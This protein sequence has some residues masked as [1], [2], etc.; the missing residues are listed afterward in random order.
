MAGIATYLAT[1]TADGAVGSLIR[2]TTAPLAIATTIVTIA[3]QGLALAVGEIE[4]TE[5]VEHAT[6]ACVR[7]SAGWAYGVVGQALIPIPVVG[8]LVGHLVGHASAY[9][10]MEGLKLARVLAEEADAA[11]EHLAWLEVQV[12][13][14]VK[15]L[16]ED[17]LA[18]EV[19]LEAEAEQFQTT[20]LPLLNEFETA[21]VAGE[22]QSAVASLL[23]LN[24]EL[25]SVLGW[26]TRPEFDEWMADSQTV[27][28]L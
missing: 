6:A 10:V 8:G 27:L 28:E 21:L 15:R 23:Q 1:T 14:S 5:L 2:Q 3:E 19:L 7:S 17:R 4:V 16:E 9:C 12:M 20:L 25:G 18:L 24:Q 22:E 13:G 11:E 26:H